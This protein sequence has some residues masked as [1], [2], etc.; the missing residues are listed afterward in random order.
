VHCRAR[1]LISAIVQ[2]V[3]GPGG[4][5]RRFPLLFFLCNHTMRKFFTL[6]VLTASVAIFTPKSHALSHC[7]E[8]SFYGRGDGFAWQTMANGQPMDPEA[9][10]TAHR[11]LPFGSLIRVTNNR[12]GRS[13]VVTVTDRGPYYGGRVLDLSHGAFS[14]IAPPSS[15]IASVC[16]TVLT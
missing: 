5:R 10:T 6:L 4:G 7:G 12:N 13:I 14:K 16:Y 15:G 1:T 9:N 3:K 11:S 8:A 2:E